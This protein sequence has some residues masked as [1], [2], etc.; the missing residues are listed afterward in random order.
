M[1]EFEYMGYMSSEA[2][3]FFKGKI[4]EEQ[5]DGLGVIGNFVKLSNG[6]THL[7][8]KGDKFKKDENGNIFVDSIYR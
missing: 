6:D 7:P 8:S 5:R 2:C 3:E 1:K 4:I